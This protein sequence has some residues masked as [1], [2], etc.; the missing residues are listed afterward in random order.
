MK[1]QT[2]HGG[3][4]EGAG[5]HK[6]PYSEKVHK[7]DLYINGSI[8]NALGGIDKIK[9]KLYNFAKNEAALIK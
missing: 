1:H 9:Q 8:I 2:K 5:R 6:K 3:K 7:I 4:R